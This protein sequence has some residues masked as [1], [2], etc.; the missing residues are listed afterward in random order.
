MNGDGGA[1]IEAGTDLP[2]QIEM[3]CGYSSPTGVSQV[4][5][6]SLH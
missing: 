4:L 1:Q 3:G 5:G 6:G 2:C